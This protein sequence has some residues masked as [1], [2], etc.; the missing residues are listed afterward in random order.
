LARI[1][2]V[3]ESTVGEDGVRSADVWRS[4]LDATLTKA[5][6]LADLYVQATKSADQR[7]WQWA[8]NY[9]KHARREARE[10][11]KILGVLEIE[12]GAGMAQEVERARKVFSAIASAAVSPS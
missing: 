10:A 8:R 3:L 5:E 12:F 1:P 7:Q 2:R 4:K 6:K 11:S 9:Y